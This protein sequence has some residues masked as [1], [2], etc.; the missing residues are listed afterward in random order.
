[1]YLQR[2]DEVAQECLGLHFE[3]GLPHLQLVRCPTDIS[4]AHVWFVPQRDHCW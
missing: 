1:M 3:D 4:A 2:E